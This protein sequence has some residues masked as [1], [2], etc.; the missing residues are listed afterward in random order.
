MIATVIKTSEEVTPDGIANVVVGYHKM[1]K[2]PV[3]PLD[4]VS[5]WCSR[6]WPSAPMISL[7]EIKD[8]DLERVLMSNCPASFYTVL[9]TAA[10][11][12]QLQSE[13]VDSEIHNGIDSA[14][15]TAFMVKPGKPLDVTAK[16]IN[17]IHASCK[18]LGV[19]HSKEFIRKWVITHP[20]VGYP[21]FAFA[22]NAEYEVTNVVAIRVDDSVYEWL[23]GMHMFN[24]FCSKDDKVQK[25][26]GSK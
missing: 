12:T 9:L 1:L 10:L 26:M 8:F 5:D 2:L 23:I 19:N 3:A 21:K 22:E 18:Q 25:F 20:Y 24:A 15:L 14:E 4:E 13:S 17:T 16:I 7:M 6:N 11:S